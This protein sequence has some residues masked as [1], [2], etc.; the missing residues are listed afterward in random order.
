MELSP[1]GAAVLVLVLSLWHAY[2]HVCVWVCWWTDI[3]RHH[4]CA[5]TVPGVAYLMHGSRSYEID[6]NSPV[7]AKLVP[8]AAAAPMVMHT[9]RSTMTSTMT[10][11]SEQGMTQGAPGVSSLYNKILLDTCADTMA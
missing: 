7:A 8:L 2:D 6:C 10:G 11:T 3:C 5:A 1:V 4:A 9:A